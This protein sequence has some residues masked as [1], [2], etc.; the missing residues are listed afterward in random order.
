MRKQALETL[1]RTA[2]FAAAT[3]TDEDL[4]LEQTFTQNG[5]MPVELSSQ[6]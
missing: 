5:A 2:W 4:W 1:P 6:R 3:A